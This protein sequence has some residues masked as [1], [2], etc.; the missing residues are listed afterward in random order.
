MHIFSVSF[1]QECRNVLLK[2]WFWLVDLDALTFPP[3]IK[4]LTKTI[5][6]PVKVG[7]P[8]QRGHFRF[9]KVLK[10]F[11]THRIT[12]EHR[13]F[14]PFLHPSYRCGKKYTIEICSRF[15]S[16]FQNAGN[17]ENKRFCF[18]SLTQFRRQGKENRWFI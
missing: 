9:L 3:I 17:I 4:R 7:A 6:H 14:Q 2:R 8:A 12:L 5:Q 18:L 15:F 11:N 10:K 1:L 16:K 13:Y